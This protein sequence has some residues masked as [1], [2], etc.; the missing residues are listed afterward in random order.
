MGTF[1]PISQTA[2]STFQNCPRMFE[3]RYVTKEAVFE[4]SEAVDDGNRLH[5]ALEFRIRDEVSLPQE[6]AHLEWLGRT[7]DVLRR[8][9][10]IEVEHWMA[11][12]RQMQPCAHNAK[13]KYL[14]GK[15]DCTVLMD[16]R[17]VTFDW[18]SGKLRRDVQQLEIQALLTFAHYPQVQVIDSALVFLNAG[19]MVPFRAQRST[20]HPVHLVTEFERYE[21]VQASGRYSPTPCGLCRAH[22]PVLSCVHNG[23]HIGK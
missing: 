19:Q 9:A 5:R 2:L 7:L 13:A 18:K 21:A 16:E 1:I 14:Q 15:D 17:A 12:D 4:P 20:F 22:C 3:G 6:F 8:R 10:V 23:R 11:V